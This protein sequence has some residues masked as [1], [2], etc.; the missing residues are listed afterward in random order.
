VKP[1][2]RGLE[3]DDRRPPHLFTRGFHGEPLWEG[4]TA[5][6]VRHRCSTHREG[7]SSKDWGNIIRGLPQN[8][9]EDCRFTE[10]ES[11][12][13]MDGHARRLLPAIPEAP[14]RQSR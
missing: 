10:Q 7:D 14:C 2:H 1:Y 9:A 8:S 3:D 13:L 5:C 12:G 11:A 6:A 4:C